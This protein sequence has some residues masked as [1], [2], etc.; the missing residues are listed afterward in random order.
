MKARFTASPCRKRL[1]TPGI[2]YRL[3]C[4]QAPPEP[5]GSPGVPVGPGMDSLAN[6]IMDASWAPASCLRQAGLPACGR[7]RP[8]SLP[9]GRRDDGTGRRRYRPELPI[10]R[11]QASGRSRPHVPLPCGRRAQARR[12]SPCRTRHAVE[13]PEVRSRESG[14][15]QAGG[16]ASRK[17]GNVSD[18][19][20]ARQ[21]ARSG[22]PGK[23]PAD[24]GQ[25]PAEPRP[26]WPRG[27]PPAVGHRLRYALPPRRE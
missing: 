24:E 20:E 7:Q 11:G 19:P 5:Q 8:R 18:C 17:R 2:R 23:V 21:K 26:S 16:R 6:L 4:L 3:P 25:K 22:G 10:R 9:S 12:R 13:G 14:Q 1:P 15:S 27:K